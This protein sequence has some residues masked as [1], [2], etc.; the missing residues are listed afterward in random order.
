MISQKLYI[1]THI[2]IIEIY[3]KHIKN[4]YIHT[5]IYRTFSA[6]KMLSTLKYIAL[7]SWNPERVLNLHEK[8]NPLHV[9]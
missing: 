8:E 9:Q 4:I 3:K 2:Y 7:L 1:H 6:F 5:H